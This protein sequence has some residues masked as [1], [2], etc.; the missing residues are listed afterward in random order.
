VVRCGCS[1]V[2]SFSAMERNSLCTSE[3]LSS[4]TVLG[5]RGWWLR[6][7]ASLGCWWHTKLLDKFAP[8]GSS[9]S[10][11][12]SRGSAGCQTHAAMPAAGT[13]PVRDEQPPSY[14]SA[15]SL[16]PFLL[17]HLQY[18]QPNNCPIGPRQGSSPAAS[19]PNWTSSTSN[20]GVNRK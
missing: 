7:A 10:V 6:W 9:L 4:S 20:K 12:K 17:P 2:L 13:E 5:T 8:H 16:A 11:G 15:P 1:L 3:R 18:H 14:P 19:C